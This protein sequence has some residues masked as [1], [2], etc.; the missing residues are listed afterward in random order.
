MFITQTDH[1]KWYVHLLVLIQSIAVFQRNKN[2]PT[3]C[4]DWV[5]KING[6]MII[7][8]YACV[9]ALRSDFFFFLW[10]AS[11]YQYYGSLL[12]QMAVWF[13]SNCLIPNLFPFHS[14]IK[15]IIN[16]GCIVQISTYKKNHESSEK[17]F[18]YKN[19]V[20]HSFYLS[21]IHYTIIEPQ[22]SKKK[23]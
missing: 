11:I 8:A 21:L 13:F 4:N 7:C 23:S 15:N 18:S 10:N 5:V 22:K 12:Q 6:N 16:Y 1:F 2:T 9:F 14:L 20:F 17:Y 3:N 19:E